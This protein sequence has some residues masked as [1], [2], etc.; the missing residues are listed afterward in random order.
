M[1]EPLYTFDNCQPAYQ[2]RWSLALFAEHPIPSPVE[3]LGSLKASTERDG[4]RLLEHQNQGNVQH[5]LINT[6][7]PVGRCV[8]VVCAQQK[9]DRKFA[10]LM[11]F[12]I[13]PPQPPSRSIHVPQFSFTYPP[14]P[15]ET[16]ANGR[17]RAKQ[18]S[19]Y[20]APLC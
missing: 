12:F 8:V 15:L 17:D 16:T 2:L 9:C 11:D 13:S 5:F 7:K 6:M 14:K 19:R 3:W 1:L 4:V 10:R 18:R 20:A